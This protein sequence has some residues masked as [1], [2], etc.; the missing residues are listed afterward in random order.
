MLSPAT[1]QVTDADRSSDVGSLPK[2]GV[3]LSTLFVLVVNLLYFDSE[4]MY[5]IQDDQQ[6]SQSD[7]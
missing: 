2:C 5:Q 4:R 3:V 7:L 1:S 6:C